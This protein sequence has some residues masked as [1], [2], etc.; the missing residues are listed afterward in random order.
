MK[1]LFG[2]TPNTLYGE[3]AGTEDA[4]AGRGPLHS[5]VQYSKIELPGLKPGSTST[6]P[7][8]R[9]PRIVTDLCTA[10]PIHLAVI[11]GITAMSGGEGPW[12]GDV[13]P[14]KLMS[15]GLLIAGLNPVSTD[16]V[17]TSLMGFSNPRAARG[18]AP[19]ENCDNHL[20]LAEQA[21]IGVA[22]LGQIDVRGLSL[23]QARCP[24]PARK[25]G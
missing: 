16:A 19:F 7:G 15:P 21:G 23:E 9:V 24:Y 12:C 10:R 1:N 17:C 6:D 4:V 14:L 5:P 11:D 3:E 20:L 18:T 8:Y 22:D 2:I 13:A 25:R